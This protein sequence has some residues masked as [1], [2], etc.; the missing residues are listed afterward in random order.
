[1]DGAT[2]RVHATALSMGTRAAVI[3]GASGTGKSDLALRCLALPV[4]N[5]IS[6][7]A[8]LIADDQVVLERRESELWASAPSSIGGKLEVR[9]IGILEINAAGPA[10][11]ALAVELVSRLEVPRLPDPWPFRDILGLK[12]PVLKLWA[13]ENSAP[14][15][16]MLALLNPALPKVR[17]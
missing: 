9:G 2:E 15:K 3:F 11:V 17:A 5:L 12:V 14:L 16:V 7:P 4:S 10:R 8:Q 6:T 13:F 1:M